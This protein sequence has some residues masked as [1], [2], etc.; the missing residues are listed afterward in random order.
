MTTERQGHPV[1]PT[2]ES[3]RKGLDRRWLWSVFSVTKSPSG[4]PALC[5]FLATVPAHIHFCF[6]LPS[7]SHSPQGRSKGV[8][9]PLAQRSSPGPPLDSK[10]CLKHRCA[11]VSW[12]T[13]R[14]PGDLQHLLQTHVPILC[15]LKGTDQKQPPEP[16][17]NGGASPEMHMRRGLTF[18]DLPRRKRDLPWA[19][20]QC[21]TCRGPDSPLD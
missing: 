15:S 11:H 5:S 17:R 1:P 3:Q 20:H 6:S 16:G 14:A 12:C 4:P 7:C 18:P 2:A 9:W 8:V 21:T 10:W 13:L 19:G